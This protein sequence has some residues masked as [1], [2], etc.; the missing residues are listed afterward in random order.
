MESVTC[1]EKK[2]EKVRP[3]VRPSVT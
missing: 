2:A 1:G 3:S